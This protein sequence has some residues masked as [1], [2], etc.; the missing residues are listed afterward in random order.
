MIGGARAALALKIGAGTLAG[1]AV[2]GLGLVFWPNV[3]LDHIPAKSAVEQP[4]FV[5]A[6]TPKVAA[7][8][9]PATTASPVAELTADKASL[10]QLASA[11]KTKVVKPAPA[12]TTSAAPPAAPPISA[13][14]A[15]ASRDAET[16]FGR[17]LAALAKG[18]IAASR[19]WLEY[20]ANDGETRAFMALGDAYNP[21][22]LTRLG[23]LGAVGDAA[24]AR[25]Y[26]NRA[27]AAGLDAARGRIAWLD[28]ANSQ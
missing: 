2:V 9:P 21:A 6:T 24:L 16:C 13:P 7:V 25:D 15:N 28:N 14:P 5:T 20:A 3:K 26:Y 27:V 4:V 19:R 22:V 1:L 11:I 10:D 23:V 12:M 18:E 8:A 17:G